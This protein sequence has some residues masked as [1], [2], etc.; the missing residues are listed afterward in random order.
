MR[1]TSRRGL[2]AGAGAAGLA[3]A[4]YA[5]AADGPLRIRRNIKDLGPHDDDVVAYRKAIVKMRA[6]G[7]WARQ[8][9]IHADMSLLHH[10]SWRFLPWHRLQV[11][12]MEKIVAS[13]SGKDDFA[14]PYWDWA[15][16]RIP[17]LFVEDAV[18]GV[19]GRECQPGDS[20]SEFLKANDAVLTDRSADDFGTFFGKPRQADQAPDSDTGRQRF[21]GS[22]EWSAHNLIHGFVG[23]D[24]GQLDTSPNDPL[25]WLHHSNVD[26]TWAMGWSHKHPYDGAYSSDEWGAE[27]LTGYVEPGGSSSPAMHASEVTST[28]ALGYDYERPRVPSVAARS[29][30]PSAPRPTR[31]V[32]Y[33][34]EMTRLGPGKGVIV[35][36]P[37]A[38]GAISASAVGYLKID[39]DPQ[40]SSKLRVSAIDLTEGQTVFDDKVFQVPMGMKTPLQGYRLNLNWGEVGPKGLK[41]EVETG[42]LVGRK[43][44]PHPP[45][46][47]KFVVDAEA[48][49]Y[50]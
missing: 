38:R 10:S 30:R 15:D 2:L 44:G 27:V 22:G 7:A 19:K 28:Q 1:R 6:S 37:E 14:M 17:E 20:I 32:H 45:T 48:R 35:L 16:D 46:I 50:A 23:G 31:T 24:M 18:F 25:F 9:A 29:G 43:A 3:A 42:P 13:L 5:Q 8:V 36:P 41:I 49:F 47:V 33:T 26:R 12:H 11:L 34:F 39:P 4:G 21:S 40:H